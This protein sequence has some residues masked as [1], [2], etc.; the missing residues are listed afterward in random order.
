MKPS[1]FWAVLP[2][3]ALLA[4]GCRAPTQEER[5]NR[6]LVDAIL[7]AITIRNARLLEEDARWAKTRH[8]ADQ[9]TDEEYQG[10]EA[11]VNKARAGDW[12]G[13]EKAGYEFR[14]KH[15]FVREGH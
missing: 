13:A 15:P 10:L 12:A 7:T 8:G 14:K 2:G 3:L 9:L 4:S 6:R 11:I 1:A 5:D